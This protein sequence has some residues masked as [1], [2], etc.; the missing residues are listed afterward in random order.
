MAGIAMLTMNR[1][2]C[3]MNATAARTPRTS[4]RRGCPPSA[5]PAAAAAELPGLS[6]V[7]PEAVTGKPRSQIVRSMNR[8]AEGN[9]DGSLNE[10]QE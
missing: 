3:A 10:L 6:W 8:L 9:T 2:S 4:Q 5:G 7:L 1:S